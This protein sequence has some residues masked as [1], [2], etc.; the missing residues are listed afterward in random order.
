MA[1][2]DYNAIIN[3]GITGDEVEVVLEETNISIG[4]IQIL[5]PKNKKM[6]KKK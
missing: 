1:K 2:I 6:V 3:E 4:N 5:P